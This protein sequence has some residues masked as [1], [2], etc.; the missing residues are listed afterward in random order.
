MP[1]YSKKPRG[2]LVGDPDLSQIGDY[3]PMGEKDSIGIGLLLGFHESARR[4]GDAVFN[5]VLE[6]TIEE[7]DIA[8]GVNLEEVVNDLDTKQRTLNDRGHPVA[9]QSRFEI[10]LTRRTLVPAF[11]A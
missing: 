5:H 2:L 9:L 1:I 7:G 6:H 11:L 10:R 4:H 3:L 8:A